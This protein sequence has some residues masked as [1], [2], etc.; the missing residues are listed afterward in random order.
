[1]VELTLFEE[2]VLRAL[3]DLGAFDESSMKTADHI[4]KK[5]NLAKGII[6]NSLVGLVNKGI[7]KRI[8]REKASGYYIIKR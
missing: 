2:K 7:I 8:V 1:L 5:I 6:G 4:M 3:T